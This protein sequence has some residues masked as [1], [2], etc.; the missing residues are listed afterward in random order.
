MRNPRSS[1]LLSLY[2]ATLC[3]SL[4]KYVNLIIT[5]FDRIPF[6]AVCSVPCNLR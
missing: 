5:S 6:G 4:I 3:R 1:I 2:H